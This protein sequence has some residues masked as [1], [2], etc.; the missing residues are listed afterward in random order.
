MEKV[1][2]ISD[3]SKE[4]LTFLAFFESEMIEKIPGYVIAKLCEEAADSRLEFYIDKEKSFEKQEISEE[5]K[6]LISHIYYDYIAEEEEKHEILK[7]WNINEEEYQKSQR[8]KYRY[9]NLFQNETSNFCMELAV[10]KEETI[11][12]KIKRFFKNLLNK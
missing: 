6:A 7:Q 9:D 12:K 1:Q 2:N 10:V 5:A 11:F 3:I 4:T 8:E